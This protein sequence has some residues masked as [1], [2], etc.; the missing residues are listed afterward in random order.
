MTNRWNQ[1]IYRLWAPIYDSTVNHFFMPGRK[2]AMELLDLKRGEKVLLVGVGTGADLP[3]LPSGVDATGIDLSPEMLAKARLKLGRCPASVK[4]IQGDAQALLMDEAPFDAV[5]L[6][7]ILSVIPDGNACLQSA[8]CALKSGGRVV[9]FDKFLPEGVTVS[10][11][12]KFINL[13]S[14]FLGTDINRR[15]SDLMR[16]CPCIITHDEPSIAGGM[17]RVVILKRI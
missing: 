17:Y 8:L 11:L 9:V 3:L 16:D 5:I 2:R 10:L 15:L 6:N 7:L 14:T 13:F 4:L 12:R 1:F